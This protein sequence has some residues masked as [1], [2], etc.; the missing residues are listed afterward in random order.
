MKVAPF[1]NKETGEHYFINL[2]DTLVGFVNLSLD[3]MFY[4]IIPGTS[5]YIFDFEVIFFITFPL[6]FGI[7][8]PIIVLIQLIL[9]L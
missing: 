9:Y 8:S 6:E 1:V 3:M 2:L 5:K 7:K 4:S